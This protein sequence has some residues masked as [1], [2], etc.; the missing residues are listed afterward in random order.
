V[1]IRVDKSGQRAIVL[2]NPE[3]GIRITRAADTGFNPDSI[4]GLQVWLKA[5]AIVA[6]DGSSVTTW[7]DS[8]S[9]NH[10]FTQGTAGSRPTYQTNELN[11]LPVVRFDGTDDS[12]LGGDLSASFPSAATLFT[13]YT[14]RDTEYSVYDHETNDG[15]WREGTTGNGYFRCFRSARINGYPATMPAT[16][17]HQFTLLSSAATYNAWL[18]GADKGAQAAA[19]MAGAGHIIG[20]NGGSGYSDIDIA[21]VLVYNS[22]L[23]APNRALVETYLNDKWGL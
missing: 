23:S 8:S 7:D 2:G 16:G 18:D 20:L 13:V 17:S 9:A 15:F 22:A 11:G 1:A 5:D 3:Y 10:D 19:Y 21:E 14:T 6:A 4:A 12:M